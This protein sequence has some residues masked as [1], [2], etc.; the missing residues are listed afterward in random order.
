MKHEVSEKL[1]SIVKNKLTEIV[2]ARMHEHMN[3]IEE[4]I[5]KILNTAITDIIGHALGMRKSFGH[6]ELDIRS[7]NAPNPFVKKINSLAEE[8]VALLLGVLLDNDV[9]LFLDDDDTTKMRAELND[10][11]R[12]LVKNSLRDKLR[13]HAYKLADEFVEQIVED[14]ISTIHSNILSGSDKKV[15]NSEELQPAKSYYDED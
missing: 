8:K 4:T 12:K 2:T 5:D 9:A 14:E 6:W 7:S 11:Y 10:S 3:V 15:M 1:S 13:D